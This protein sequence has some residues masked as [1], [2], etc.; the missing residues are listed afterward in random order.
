MPDAM[1]GQ[2]SLLELQRRL[3]LAQ[4][5]AQNPGES[6]TPV[7]AA[8]RGLAQVLAAR[9]AGNLTTQIDTERQSQNEKNVAAL[10]NALGVDPAKFAGVD[11]RM[12]GSLANIYAQQNTP[13]KFDV[14]QVMGPDGVPIYEKKR[15]AIGKPAYVAP[16]TSRPVQVMGENGL[17]KWVSAE[18][19]IGMP[20]YVKPDDAPDTG[21]NVKGE[22]DLRKEFSVIAK[23]FRER[24]EAM[25]NLIASAKKPSPGG[26][27]ALVTQFMKLLDPGSVVREGEFAT[28]AQAAGIGGRLLGILQRVDSGERLTPEQRA[29]LVSRGGMI[30]DEA[31]KNYLAALTDYEGIAEQYG[32]NPGRIGLRQPRYKPE[33]YMQSVPATS[34]T[35]TPVFPRTDADPEKAAKAARRAQLAEKYGITLP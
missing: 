30:Y 32:F 26:D 21:P 1:T 22:S 15:D 14:V 13:E 29:D 24:E 2:T 11:E 33:D 28:A 12:I 20:A 7:G 8:L 23:P 3:A 27:I 9:N 18:D 34:Q 25:G 31:A 5:M 4:Q 16:K 19:A 6:R 17:P 10:A 35:S